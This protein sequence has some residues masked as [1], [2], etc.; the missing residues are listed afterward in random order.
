MQAFASLCNWRKYGFCSCFRTRANRTFSA[1]F[2]RKGNFLFVHIFGKRISRALLA[3]NSVTRHRLREE[4]CWKYSF[5]S[6]FH[7]I[8]KKNGE[9]ISQIF[10]A[11]AWCARREVKYNFRCWRAKTQASTR[12]C[13]WCEYRFEL[14]LK[15]LLKTGAFSHVEDTQAR[16]LLEMTFFDHWPCFWQKLLASFEFKIFVSRDVL[17]P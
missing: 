7:R 8:F 12:F 1:I 3:K 16:L 6:T 5:G 11:R 2:A 13:D 9:Q 15:V 4:K 10:F 14:V 17:L